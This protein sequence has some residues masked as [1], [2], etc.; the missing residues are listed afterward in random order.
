MEQ[1]FAQ[2]P[3]PLGLGHLTTCSSHGA[4]LR[5]SASPT[6]TWPPCNLL[7][8]WSNVLHKYLSHWDL[9]TLQLIPPMEQRFAQVPISLRLRHLAARSPH[10]T[11]LRSSTSHTGTRYTTENKARHPHKCPSRTLWDLICLP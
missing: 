2:G 9:A 11:Q 1:R 6:G 7:L 4:T 8:P 3:F 10:R 5:T